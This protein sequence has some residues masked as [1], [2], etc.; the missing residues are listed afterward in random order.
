MILVT[1]G[2]QFALKLGS[3]AQVGYRGRV[4]LA[5]VGRISPQTWEPTQRLDSNQ[6][7]LKLNVDKDK[8]FLAPTSGWN[9][10]DSSQICFFSIAYSKGLGP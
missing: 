3:P 4:Q 10:Q 5:I 2:L 9:S 7:I 1:K 8:L 6:N